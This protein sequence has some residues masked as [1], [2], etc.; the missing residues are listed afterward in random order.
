[1]LNSAQK[2]CCTAII[3][4]SGEH[5]QMFHSFLPNQHTLPLLQAQALRPQDLIYKTQQHGPKLLHCEETPVYCQKDWDPSAE[6]QW[7]TFQRKLQK[8]FKHICL[9]QS[10]KFTILKAISL[11]WFS[12]IQPHLFCL[13]AACLHLLPFHSIYAFFIKPD[14]I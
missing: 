5:I 14:L 12:L 8:Q 7:G 2:R 10:V 4:T 3:Y 1:M 6:W 13:A 9:A 11:C